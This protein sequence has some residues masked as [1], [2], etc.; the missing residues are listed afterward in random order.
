M[1]RGGAAALA[2]FMRLCLCRCCYCAGLRCTAIAPSTAL[3]RCACTVHEPPRVSGGRRPVDCCSSHRWWLEPRP[4][5]RAR[6]LPTRCSRIPWTLPL[7]AAPPVR[8]MHSR[9][10][11]HQ[12][13]TCAG[14]FCACACV[15]DDAWWQVV[16]HV[17]LHIVQGLA[18]RWLAEPGHARATPHN[19]THTRVHEK[20]VQPLAGGHNLLTTWDAHISSAGEAVWRHGR[21][22]PLS[23]SLIAAR[24]TLCAHC[25]A[26]RPQP[27]HVHVHVHVR[28]RV[29]PCTPTIPQKMLRRP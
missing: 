23:R 29:Q 27:R 19:H 12:P 22:R 16:L 13:C 8:C 21:T 5:T 3:R 25:S 17:Q 7:A 10:L 18:L 15:V 28:A 2:C 26:A 9:C 1:C 20:Q 24:R 11:C 14:V 4:L 6:V